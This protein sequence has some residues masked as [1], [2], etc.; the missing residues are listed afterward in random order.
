MIAVAVYVSLDAGAIEEE[1]GIR[2]YMNSRRQENIMNRMYI[3]V[4]LRANMKR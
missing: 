4:I 3:F 1:D 2:Y